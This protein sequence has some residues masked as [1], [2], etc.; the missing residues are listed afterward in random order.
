MTPDPIFFRDLAYVFIAAVVG[1]TSA[2]LLRQ[3]LILG[4]VFGGILISPLT[5]GP[6]ISDVHSFEMFAE[7]GVILLMFCIGIEFSLNDL[8]R[9][10]WVALLGGPIGIVLSILLGVG[11]GEVVGWNFIQSV[12]IGAVVSVASTMVLARLLLDS[13]DLRAKHGRVMI[14]ITLVEDLAVVVLTVLLPALGALEPGRFAAIGKALW[15][16]VLILVPFSY[17]ASKAIPPLLTRIAKTQNAELFLLVSLSL[18][19]GTAAVTQMAGLSLALGAFLAGLIISGSEYGHEMLARLLSLRDAFVALFFVTIGILI[20]PRVVW[21]NLPLLGLMLGLIIIGKFVIWTLVVKL[22]RYAWGTALLVGVGLTQI[23]EFS[24]VLVQVAKTAGH[25]GE[26]VYNATLAASLL[27]ILLNA[28]LVRYA[29]RGIAALH[30]RMGRVSAPI[31][32][33]VQDEQA[34]HVL[35]CGFG[36]M[37]ST[38]GLALDHFSIPYTVIERDP[39]LVRQLR[40]RGISCVY[41]DASQTELLNAAGA[42]RAALAIV[43]LPVLSEASLTLRRLRTLNEKLPVLVRAH[44]FREAEDLKDVGATEIILPEV[45]GAHTLIR[46]AFQALKVPKSNILAYLK[47][48]QDVRSSDE[49]TDGQDVEVGKAGTGRST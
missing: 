47:S 35:V 27:S 19:I 3:P 6:S 32:G 15:L 40:R 34:G 17:L 9:V 45:E 38:V 5:P 11:V 39:D 10:R 29:P 26:D 30:F 36:R 49:G 41:G 22:F 28:P 14:G 1:G 20:D 43:A 18:G 33:G 46:H 12:V 23:G 7:I 42:E 4:Y 24:F 25:V 44:G 16:A 13:G 2:Y 48:C 8:L 37:G 21:S 31:Q